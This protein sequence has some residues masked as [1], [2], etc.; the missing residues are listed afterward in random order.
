MR[1]VISANV[2]TPSAFD[3]KIYMGDTLVDEQIGVATAG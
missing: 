2:D 3:V 1:L